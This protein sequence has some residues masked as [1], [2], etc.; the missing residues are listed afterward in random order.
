MLHCN[1]PTF[2]IGP[3][4]WIEGICTSFWKLLYLLLFIY[5]FFAS[6][7]LFLAQ[8]VIITP[9]NELRSLCRIKTT[10][11][12]LWN[13]T[14]TF[15]S[16]ILGIRTHSNKISY[17]L[18]CRLWVV[19]MS[20]QMAPWMF[21]SFSRLSS[22]FKRVKWAISSGITW[23]YFLIIVNGKNLIS[24]EYCGTWRTCI[25]KQL[26]YIHIFQQSIKW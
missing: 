19:I 17:T 25:N 23:I 24:H 20:H 14:I 16:H 8:W 1:K 6:Q 13:Y 4:E 22:N 5:L 2:K 26:K 11:E 9:E 18:I 21:L 7:H 3:F 15:L 12:H 10:K